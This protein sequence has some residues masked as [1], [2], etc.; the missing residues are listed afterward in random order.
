MWPASMWMTYEKFIRKAAGLG[1]SPV[2]DDPDV[3]H[4]TYAHCDV[5]V[6]GGGPAG[7]AAASAAANSGARV[8]LLDEGSEFGGALLGTSDNKAAKDFVNSAIGELEQLENVRL[9]NRTTATGY[10]DYNYITAL[11]KVTDHLGPGNGGDAP[12]QRFWKIRAKQVVIA[13]GSIERPLVFADNDRP[14]VMLANAVGTYVNR[15]GVLPGND[16]VVFTNNDSAYQVALDAAGAG[17]TVTTVDTCL[18]Y[19]SDAADE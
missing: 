2:E 14:G 4:G 9:L 5:L 3:Y 1:V 17:A 7:I 6:I 18:L 16:I 19:T 12:R 10:Y 15:Y 8:M 13:A 11:E